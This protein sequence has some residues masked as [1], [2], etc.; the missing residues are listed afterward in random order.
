MCPGQR[1]GRYDSSPWNAACRAFRVINIF[2]R[3]TVSASRKTDVVQPCPR[4]ATRPWRSKKTRIQAFAC[5]FDCLDSATPFPRTDVTE[6]ESY[7]LYDHFA[8][9]NENDLICKVWLR[10]VFDRFWRS[11]ENLIVLFVWF[12]ATVLSLNHFIF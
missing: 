8:G 2:V 3:L 12:R 5:C 9:A 1:K 7:E 11:D 10:R 4:T 6:I